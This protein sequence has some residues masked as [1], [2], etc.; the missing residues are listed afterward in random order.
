MT[1]LLSSPTE[2][3]KAAALLAKEIKKTKNQ[4][5]SALVIGLS[6]NLGTGKTTFIQGFARG[7]KIK[8]KITSPTFLIFRSYK[9][10]AANYKFFYH[11]DVYRIEKAGDIQALGFKEI[12]KNPKNI[13]IIEWA[14]IPKIPLT[15][16]SLS[17]NLKHRK[18]R[19]ER[20][21]NLKTQTK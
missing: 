1:L 6:G 14:D 13:V 2:T 8:R 7:L 19:H 3:R 18:E 16:T 20:K 4:P 10:R 9:L 17:V 12:I 11:V 5:K 15:N 21:I